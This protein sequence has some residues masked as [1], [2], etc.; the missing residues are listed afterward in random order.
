MNK[1]KILVRHMNGKTLFIMVLLI[2]ALIYPV[3]VNV[4]FNIVLPAVSHVKNMILNIGAQILGGGGGD[5]MP[6][7][8]HP[9]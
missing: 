6:G 7:E 5:E 8:W 1:N 4:T 3:I 2:T 9:A